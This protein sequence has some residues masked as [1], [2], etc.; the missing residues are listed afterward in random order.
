MIS[1]NFGVS[2]KENNRDDYVYE[3]FRKQLG[4][5]SGGYYETSLIWKENDSPLQ[6]NENISLGNLSN[7]IRE[8]NCL[9]S[10]EAYDKVMQGRIS[11]GIVER[12][13]ESEKSVDIQKRQ[14]IFYYIG[15]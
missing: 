12:V 13:P 6:N 10:L 1:N 5:R 8:L 2:E 7:L 9:K 4:H 3:K 11:E 15:L 14:K